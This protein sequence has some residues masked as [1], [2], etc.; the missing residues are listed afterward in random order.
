MLEIMTLKCFR[1][2][3]QKIQNAVIYAI[4]ADESAD[5]S[6]KDQHFVCIRW[7][8]DEPMVHKDFIGMHPMQGTG[9]DQITFII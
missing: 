9:A 4:I 6:N 2:I 3:A 5:V 7:I 8:D 1:E